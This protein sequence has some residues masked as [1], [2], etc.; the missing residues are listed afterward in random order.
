MTE[1]RLHIDRISVLG[2]TGDADEKAVKKTVE[3]AMRKL[4][5]RLARSPFA[6]SGAMALALEE[7][8]LSTLPADELLGERGAERLADELYSAILRRTP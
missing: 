5:E 6:R 4:A 3:D 1:L 8:S 7:L 2:L